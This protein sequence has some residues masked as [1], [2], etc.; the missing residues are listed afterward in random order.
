LG[1][2]PLKKVSEPCKKVW[3]LLTGTRHLTKKEK[4][5]LFELLFILL[6]REKFWQKGF[7]KTSEFIIK[8][9]YKTKKK[10]LSNNKGILL[11]LPPHNFLV[12]IKNWV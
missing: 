3:P 9:G 1:D 12:L 2:S 4:K 10:T 8:K 7:F 6:Q 11:P 5:V